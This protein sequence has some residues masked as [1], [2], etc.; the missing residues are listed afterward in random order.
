MGGVGQLR[1]IKL[2]TLMSGLTIHRKQ[3]Y[4][5]GGAFEA[6]EAPVLPLNYTR[7]ILHRL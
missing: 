5:T 3:L 1:S 2:S 7:N 4:F 6:W